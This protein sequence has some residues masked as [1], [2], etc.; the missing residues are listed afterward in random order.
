MIRLET[1]AF[2][3]LALF[4]I[5]LAAQAVPWWMLLPFL[6]WIA[7]MI[8]V[9]LETNRPDKAVRYRPDDQDQP[10]PNEPYWY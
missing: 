2:S 3:V 6:L 1:V 5:G 9:A 4:F 10:N 7:S 8:S